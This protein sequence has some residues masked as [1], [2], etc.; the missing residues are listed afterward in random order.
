MT[1]VDVQAEIMLPNTETVS[2]SEQEVKFGNEL[3]KYR[4]KVIKTLKDF[5]GRWSGEL[6]EIDA[7]KLRSDLKEGATPSYQHLYRTAAKAKTSG[8]GD[9]KY[10]R[11]RGY[12]AR[13]IQ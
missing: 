1:I 6:G 11:C 3:E 9:G 8:Q 4:I 2:S 13:A 10:A 7:I 12:Q 5:V